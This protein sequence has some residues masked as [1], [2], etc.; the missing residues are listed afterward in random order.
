[1]QLYKVRGGTKEELYA[2][3]YN[4]GVAISLGNKWFTAENVV[5]LTEW[6]LE[7]TKEYVVVYVADSIHAINIEIRKRKSS[8]KAMEMAEKMSDA[9]L[10]EIKL[11]AETRLSTSQLSKIYYEKWNGLF[12]PAFQEKLNWLNSKY[13]T[14]EVFRKTIINLVEGFTSNESKNFSEE[15]KIQLGT[16]IIAELPEL[17]GRTPINGRSFDADAYPY[18]GKLA[19][20]VEDIQKGELFPDVKDKVMDTEPKVFIEV[21]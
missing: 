12:T 3:K 15:D 9:I 18:D 8:T 13:E 16:Y 7:Y 10:E 2:K 21:H 20:F 1:M 4:I 14:D 11:L 17:L 6:A 19:E 5:S